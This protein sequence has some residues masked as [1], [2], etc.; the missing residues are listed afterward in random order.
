MTPR[1]VGTLC[2][3]LSAASFGAMAIFARQAYAGG[4]DVTAVLLLRFVIAA[5]LLTCLMLATGRRWPKGRNLALLLAMG[6]LCYVGQSMSFFSALNHAS[7]GLVALLLYLHPFLVTVSGSLILRR[8]LGARRMLAVLAALLGTALTLGGGMSGEPLGIALGLTAAVIYSIYILVGAR[9]L[10]EEDPLAAVTVVM[11]G[12]AI[13]F[14][15][16]AGWQQPA[17]PATMPAWGAVFAIAIVC[18]VVAMLGLFIGI[19]HLGPA[20]AATLLTLE[21]VVTIALAAI[22][23]GEAFTPL[24]MLGGAIV[25]AAVVWLARAGGQAPA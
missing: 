13:V 1:L 16:L 18:T 4:A 11:I 6:G 8:P 21:P 7:A 14:A 15:L 20:D 12:A 3:A 17:F 19:R 2:V 22:F 5:A 25:L 10:A 23:L 9:A 24:Q